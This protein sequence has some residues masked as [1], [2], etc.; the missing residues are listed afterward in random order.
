MDE[1]SQQQQHQHGKDHC[2]SGRGALAHRLSHLIDPPPDR[3]RNL[4]PLWVPNCASTSCDLGVFVYQPAE[5][6]TT[7]QVTLG[8]R[9]RRW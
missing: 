5:P 3:C 6:I 9:C 1:T 7:S 8:W 4:L 2:G